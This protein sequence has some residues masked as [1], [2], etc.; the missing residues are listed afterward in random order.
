MNPQ[1]PYTNNI[2]QWLGASSVNDLFKRAKGPKTIPANLL[3]ERIA[4]VVTELET[5]ETTLANA[6]AALERTVKHQSE[7][8]Q[9][10]MTV[11]PMWITQAANAVAEAQNTIM[12]KNEMA[13]MLAGIIS[14]KAA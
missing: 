4:H 13:V 2:L 12:A 10:G 1:T 3:A 6:M 7:L 11:Y 5:A 9:T 14:P 8:H